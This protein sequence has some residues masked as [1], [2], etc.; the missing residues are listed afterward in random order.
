MGDE[1]LKPCPHC[2]CDTPW[3][4]SAEHTQGLR[5]YVFCHA[6]G[7]MGGWEPTATE[8]V[9]VWNTRANNRYAYEQRIVGDGSDWGEIMRDAYDNLMATACESC[10]PEQMGQLADYIR[11]ELGSGTCHS[12]T[13]SSAWCFVCSE[14]G[15]SFPRNKLHLAHNHGEINYCPNCGR[16]VER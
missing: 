6:C 5:W 16:L 7:A 14:C 4:E 2:E 11:A 10:T 12:T 15:K 8:A 9:A 3:L 13:D 1:K